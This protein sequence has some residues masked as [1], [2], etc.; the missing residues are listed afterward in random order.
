MGGKNIKQKTHFTLK[1]KLCHFYS[2]MNEINIVIHQQYLIQRAILGT[3]PRQEI[4]RQ[5]FGYTN[6]QIDIYHNLVVNTN[7]YSTTV[8]FLVASN[9]RCRSI[10]LVWTLRNRPID[11]AYEWKLKLS[12]YVQYWCSGASEWYF[13][14]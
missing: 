10:F 4:L 8:Y 9:T 11:A 5:N 14:T 3:I 13:A 6:H 1:T 7:I 2:N 12:H